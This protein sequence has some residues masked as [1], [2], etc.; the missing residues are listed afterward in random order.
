[1]VVFY[2]LLV[3]HAKCPHL[4]A[5]VQPRLS[6]RG[7]MLIHILTTRLRTQAE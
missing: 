2:L 7:W 3:I 4:S 5:P 6:L 1:M